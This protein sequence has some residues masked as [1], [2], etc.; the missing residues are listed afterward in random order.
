MT[1]A[2]QHGG[3]PCGALSE[4]SD[5]PGAH[6]AG[7]VTEWTAFSACSDQ[8]KKT[9]SRKLLQNLTH[10]SC[11]LIETVNCAV[12]CKLTQ[13]GAWDPSQCGTDSSGA[14]ILQQRRTRKIVAQPQNGGARCD[15]LV[16]KR[17][18][19]GVPTPSPS[20]EPKTPTPAPA[21]V[22][23]AYLTAVETRLL[24]T[25]PGALD[26]VNVALRKALIETVGVANGKVTLVRV[27]AEQAD[28]VQ[29]QATFS[30][31][32]PADAHQK[33][34]RLEA[35]GL[36]PDELVAALRR[37]HALNVAVSIIGPTIEKELLRQDVVRA[38]PTANDAGEEYTRIIKVAMRAYGYTLQTFGKQTRVV[39]VHTF[40]SMLYVPASA[41]EISE[42]RMQ[43]ATQAEHASESFVTFDLRVR[44][45][46]D[47]VRITLPCLQILVRACVGH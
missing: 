17:Q 31:S 9:R 35:L 13:W 6:C 33:A 15:S 38:A 40:A 18:C 25:G 5:C 24:L 47:E 22:P 2:S 45:T 46:E 41:V 34:A 32:N 12:N 11:P 30:V 4:Q 8:G 10:V 1:R 23:G 39:F 20:P 29:L 16:E 14:T 26:A 43:T 27:G 7:T 37:Q 19:E 28:R 3:Q 21:A 42:V 36:D 44:C